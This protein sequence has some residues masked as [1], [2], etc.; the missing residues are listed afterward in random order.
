MKRRGEVR[1]MET[2]KSTAEIFIEHELTKMQEIVGK[3]PVS[4]EDVG[5]L[6]NEGF[7]VLHK[8]EEL[9]ISRDRLHLTINKLKKEIKELKEANK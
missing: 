6:I 1:V 7:R 8:C 4:V 5:E 2:K 9:R 3:Q